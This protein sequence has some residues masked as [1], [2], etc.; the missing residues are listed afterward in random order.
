M[1]GVKFLG[2]EWRELFRHAIREAKRLKIEIGFN[3]A[4]GWTMMGPWVTQDDAMKKVVQSELK[5]K[6]PQKFSGSLPS[7]ET[8]DGYYREIAVQAFPTRDSGISV[9]SKEIID[10]TDRW[11]AD[12]NFQWDVPE[13]EWTILRTGYTLTGSKWFPYPMG[14]TFDGGAGYQIDYMNTSSLRNYFDFLGKIVLE[15]SRKAGGQ[16]TYPLDRQL[17]GREADLDAGFR[18]SIPEVP[19][20][21]SGAISAGAPWRHSGQRRRDRAIPGRLRSDDRRL[22]G[23]ELL[24]RV[25]HIVS[26]QR[27]ANARRSGGARR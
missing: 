16:L 22:P 15:E 5:L 1:P 8:V 9:D 23:G 6:G 10:I 2:A 13:G 7:P 3:L 11:R 12:R 4:G 20:L 27:C 17:G 26:H 19:W 24:W 18:S 21:R 14:D 25:W